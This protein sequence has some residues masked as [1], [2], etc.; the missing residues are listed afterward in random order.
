MSGDR[1]TP[2]VIA[3]AE[4]AHRAAQAHFRATEPDDPE[5]LEWGPFRAME[6]TW[7]AA[8]ALIAAYCAR[9]GIGIR[10]ARARIERA[11]VSV[12]SR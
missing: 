9:E 11:R 5:M 2:A 1:I 4:D 10:E 12:P 6:D 7:R 8:R 3:A